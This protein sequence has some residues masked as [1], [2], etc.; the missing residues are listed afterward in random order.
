MDT[1]RASYHAAYEKLVT[2]QE[3]SCGLSAP[4]VSWLLV[5]FSNMKVKHVT[6]H[7]T[8]TSSVNHG[9]PRWISRTSFVRSLLNA[10]RWM[11]E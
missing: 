2:F 10:P 11:S 5:L 8:R 7:P 1:D 4:T 6:S 3:S 9:Q